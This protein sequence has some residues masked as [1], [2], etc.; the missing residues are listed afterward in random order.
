MITLTNVFKKFGDKIILDDI[1]LTVAPGEI[2]VLLGTSGSGKTTLLRSIN[3]LLPLDGG[4]ITVKGMD[5]LTI[6]P[7]LLR[8]QMGYVLQYHG[9]FPHYTVAENIALVPQLL[10]WDAEKIRHRVHVLLE[11]LHLSPPEHAQL[12]P[13]QLSGGQQQ[14][15][16][17]ARA[18]AAQPPI[19]L[20][21][22]PFGALDPITRYHV[23]KEVMALDEIRDKTIVLVTHDVEEAFEMGHRICLLHEGRVQQLGTPATLLLHPANDFVRSFFAAQRLSLEWKTIGLQALWPFLPDAAPGAMA[24][25]MDL[26]QSSWDALDFLNTHHGKMLHLQHGNATKSVDSAALLLAIRR[27]KQA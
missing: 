26:R 11:K 18:L 22:E 19:L 23:R 15:V 21:D 4:S 2:L 6:P 16:G 17:L 14:R 24:P 1:S 12:Y 7:E 8:R 10:G 20:M 13:R 25:V 5:I 9:L 3:R 27:Y